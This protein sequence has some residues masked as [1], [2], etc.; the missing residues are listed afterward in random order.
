M[1]KNKFITAIFFILVIIILQPNVRHSIYETFTNQDIASQLGV[2][3]GTQTKNNDGDKSDRQIIDDLKKQKYIS[4]HQVVQINNNKPT[5]S[6]EDLSIAKDHWEKYSNLDMLNRVGQADALLSINSMP[7][8]KRESIANVKPTG[9]KNK[10][11]IFNGKKDY[12]YNRSHLIGFQLTGQ[13]ANPK[14]LFTG[15]RALNANFD[16]EQNSMVYYENEVA[17][18]IRTTRNHVRYQVTPVFKGMELLARGVRIQAQSIEDNRISFDVYVFNVQ[19][20]YSL[21]YLTGESVVE[22]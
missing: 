18:Y 9:W 11:I 12:L 7:T 6:N 5:F 13:N 22:K 16:D 10:K 3:Q 4:P 8:A 20:G 1:K 14:N 21:D 2:S 17:N 15:T 19:P